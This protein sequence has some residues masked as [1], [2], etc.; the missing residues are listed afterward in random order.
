MKYSKNQVVNATYTSYSRFRIPEGIDIQKFLKE[1][2]A[3]VI[4]D[5][6]YIV[7]DDKTIVI[8]SHWSAADTMNWKRPRNVEVEDFEPMDED[9]DGDGELNEDE[10]SEDEEKTN[11]NSQQS[12]GQ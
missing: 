4:W 10:D 2:K 6:L 3:W 7:L 1:G 12:H 5:K 11:Q 8:E 9:E